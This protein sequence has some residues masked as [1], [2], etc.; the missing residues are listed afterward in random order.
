MLRKM[1]K[2]K[3]EHDNSKVARRNLEDVFG[4]WT[5][6]HLRDD[7]SGIEYGQDWIVG[8]VEESGDVTGLEFRVQSKVL[9]SK[10][11]IKDGYITTSVNLSTINYLYNLSSF[12]LFHFFYVPDKQGYYLWLDDW[13]IENKKPNWDSLKTV[14]VKIPLTAKMDENTRSQIYDRLFKDSHKAKTLRTVSRINEMSKDH[15]VKVE[16]NGNDTFFV[17]NAKH[18]GAIPSI[19]PLDS[20]A[21]S[22][23]Q[24]AIELGVPTDLSGTFQI[25]NSLFDKL[26]VGTPVGLRILPNLEAAPSM[27][28]RLRL[29]NSSNQIVYELKYL[30]L[31]P[32]QVGSLARKWSANT[33][34]NHTIFQVELGVAQEVIS[35]SFTLKPEQ[36]PNSNST[37]WVQFF[38]VLSLASQTMHCQLLHLATDMVLVQGDFTFES[39]ESNLLRLLERLSRALMAIESVTDTKIPIPETFSESDVI[40]AET[41][42]EVLSTGVYPKFQEPGVPKDNFPAILTGTK[43]WGQNVLS[44]NADS[45]VFSAVYSEAGEMT[46]QI[47][48]QRVNLGICEHVFEELKFINVH[49]QS[50]SHMEIRFM[51]NREKFYMRFPKWYKPPQS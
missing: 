5:I 29:L 8:I 30:V 51:V 4:N 9:S 12:V 43:E 39:F 41:I 17:V 25:S 34:N 10:K 19:T 23:L 21:Q 45:E 1:P 15:F 28:V 46:V 40:L 31:E 35:F 37:H 26:Q 16:F 7:S 49:S 24:K 6:A 3:I 18:E 14:T 50:E 27:P 22:T 47:L 38:D 11:A 32:I 36:V 33:T 13:Y 44:H 42:E 2:W 48:G 20:E